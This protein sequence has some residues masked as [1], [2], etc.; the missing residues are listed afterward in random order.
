[1][2]EGLGFR[3][4]EYARALLTLALAQGS[5]IG[6]NLSDIWINVHRALYLVASKIAP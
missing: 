6:F 3:L 5:W 4:E 2:V 1:M